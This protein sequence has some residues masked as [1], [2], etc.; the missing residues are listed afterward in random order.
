MYLQEERDVGGG[1][2]VSRI[3]NTPW[4][5]VKTVIKKRW[6]STAAWLCL[7]VKVKVQGLISEAANH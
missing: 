5:P 1:G 3:I 6:N 7:F 4:Y 2:G